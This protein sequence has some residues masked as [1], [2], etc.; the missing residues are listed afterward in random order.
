VPGLERVYSLLGQ[1]D[2]LVPL[3]DS[4]VQR[5]PRDPTLRTVQLRT[6]SGL[7]RDDDARQA[8]E[9]WLQYVPRDATPYREYARLLLDAGRSAAADTVLLRAQRAL[10][11]S[12]DV[13]AE[14]AQLRAA[15]GL[16]EPSA[17]SWR[18]AMRLMPYLDQAAVF[19]LVQA[20]VASR[21]SIR[22]AFLAPPAEIPARKVLASLETRWRSPREGWGALRELPPTDSSMAAWVQFAEQAE[23]AG[24][25]LTA[26]DALV[27][28]MLVRPSERLAVRAANDAVEGGDPGSALEIIAAARERGDAAQG[29]DFLP[30]EVRALAALGRAG[31]AE[32]RVAAQGAQL[33]SVSRARLTRAIAFG[34]VRAGD[35]PRARA[36]LAQAGGDDDDRTAGLLALYEGDLAEARRT[37]KHSIDASPDLVLALA[38]LSRTRADRSPGAGAAFLALA[39]GDT[40][41]ALE[42]FVAAAK[43]IPDAAPLLIASA[44]R[45]QMA[46]HAD[47]LAAP[48]WSAVVERYPQAPEAPEAE[49]ELARALRR[50]GDVAQ[51]IARLEHMILT[52]PRSALIPQARRELELARG[53][54]PHQP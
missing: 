38:L 33:D 10:G 4:L 36:A 17:R 50:S 41:T 1:T 35:L 2:S 32:A 7:R 44:A 42:R 51:A 49:L 12:R 9:R 31:E 34:W 18:E 19:S 40:A 25:W 30:I 3:I 47:S 14:L 11:G 5:R 43:E 29:H 26:R 16:W 24:A 39:Q 22:A 8:F 15:M 23:E 37:L 27:A 54:V 6:L 45:L 53:S 13:S 20:P 46:R 52:Y 28:A 48:L 21:D